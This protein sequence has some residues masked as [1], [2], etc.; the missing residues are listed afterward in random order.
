MLN[1]IKHKVKQHR[2]KRALKKAQKREAHGRHGTEL[3]HE[4]A[5][6]YDNAVIHWTAPEYIRHE[7]GL[8]WKVAAATVISLLMVFAVMEDS[9]TFSLAIIAFAATYYLVHLE[10]PKRVEVKLSNIGIK[11][12]KRM[13]S[14][15]KIK[16]FWIC[17]MPPHVKT[18][19]IHVDG[20]LVNDITIQLDGQNPSDVREFLLTK[21][22]ELE[23]KSESLGDAILRILKI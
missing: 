18:L 15:G 19:N 10:H 5:S 1:K 7:R 3:S 11:V 13:Y 14:Y 8:L 12:G 4:H 17:Y 16:A 22:P 21:I 20:G 23:G 2:E 6:A 9:L